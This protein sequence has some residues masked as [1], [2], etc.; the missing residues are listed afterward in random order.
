MVEGDVAAETEELDDLGDLCL[1]CSSCHWGSQ[2]VGPSTSV[3]PLFGPVGPR[4]KEK[5]NPSPLVSGEVPQLRRDR[6]TG[7]GRVGGPQVLQMGTVEEVLS[8]L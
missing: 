3:D 2:G 4:R 5:R 6:S 7:V 8:S 1:S